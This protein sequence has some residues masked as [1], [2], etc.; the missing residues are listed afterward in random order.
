MRVV[1][2]E[3][4]LARRED[5]REIEL[6]L[7]RPCSTNVSKISLSTSFGRAS[8]RSILLIT[9]IGRMWHANALRSTNLVCGIGPSKASTRTASAPSAIW[10]VR[11]T[12]PPKSAWPGVSIRLILISP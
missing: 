9:T 8:G 6:I 10:S 12:S 3:A 4:G 2:G 5:V 7:A 11:S 1:R